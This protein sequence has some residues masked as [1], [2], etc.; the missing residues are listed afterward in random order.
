MTIATISDSPQDQGNVVGIEFDASAFDNSILEDNITHY[1]FWRHYDPTGQ[2]IGTLDEGNWELIGEMPAQSF[3]GYAYQAATLGNTNAF[4]TFNS[5]YTIVAHTDDDDTYWYSNVVCGE[6]VDNLAPMEPELE[7]MVLETG[8]VTVFWELPSEED[9]AYTEV[10]SDAGFAAEVTG[11]TLAVD[12]SVEL[13]ETYTYTAVHYDVN[14]NASDPSSLT[15]AL[16]LGSDVITLNA[17]WNLIS[18]DRAVT[19]R[20]RGLRRPCCRQFAIRHRI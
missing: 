20:R 15:L 2:S 18:T 5:C 1:A 13:G 3:S 14:G 16:E 11:D 10:T 6:S 4:G 17:G 9:Y 8:G 12:L 7:G 19:Q